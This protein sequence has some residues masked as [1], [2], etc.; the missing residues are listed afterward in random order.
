MLCLSYGRWMK[1]A[2]ELMIKLLLVATT[3]LFSI[4]SY[5][6]STESLSQMF[7]IEVAMDQY[8]TNVW[9]PLACLRDG[10]PWLQDF[11]TSTPT[12]FWHIRR[13]IIVEILLSHCKFCDI[14]C[15]TSIIR[16]I[17]HPLV[18]LYT[19]LYNRMEQHTSTFSM[20]RYIWTG[21]H[22]QCGNMD[23]W[24][25]HAWHLDL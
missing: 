21:V 4:I 22:K 9:V 8:I 1:M 13:Y 17:C 16:I 12:R 6:R 14:P 10:R 24:C 2:H 25:M 18:D 20:L 5:V 23:V 3:W 11:D 7:R 15:C 19:L